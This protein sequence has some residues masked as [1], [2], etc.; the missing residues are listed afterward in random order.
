MAEMD[1]DALLAALGVEVAP[2]KATSRTPL[3]ERIVA[4]FEDI[5]RFHQQHGR[6]P[7]HG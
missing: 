6:A 1:D 7:Q 5:L 2:P 4:G 3:E